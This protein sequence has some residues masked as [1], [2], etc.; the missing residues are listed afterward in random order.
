MLSLKF[1]QENKETVIERLAIK[2]FDARE[3]IDKIIALDNLRKSLQQ[4]AESK[5]A[6]MNRIAKE[7]GKL[8]QTGQK[9]EAEKA[10]QETSQ[11]KN[12]IA[13]LSNRRNEV[14]NQLTDLL[15]RIPNLPHAS[16]PKGKSDADNEIV[17][18]ISGIEYFLFP[19]LWVHD[20]RLGRLGFFFLNVIIVFVFYNY[21]II[22]SGDSFKRRL[23]Q[24]Q[25]AI[26]QNLDDKVFV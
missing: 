22:F 5:Q 24:L 25:I 14:S 17:K 9:E 7:I 4:E 12:D 6:E 21:T 15:L 19:Q 10:R 18:G 23:Y 20:N 2:N 13:E 16:V 1:I 11:L 26:F 3:P 8:M